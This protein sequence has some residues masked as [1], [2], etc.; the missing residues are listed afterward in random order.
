MRQS[1]MVFANAAARSSAITAPT[2]GMLTYLSDSGGLFIYNGSA[3][4]GAVNASSL[5]GQYAL[6][7]ADVG[8]NTGTAGAWRMFTLP[9]GKM[10]LDV[11]SIVPYGGVNDI[12]YL[13]G[14]CLG[15]WSGVQ[16]PY[17]AQVYCYLGNAVA[18][19][20]STIRIYYR[21]PQ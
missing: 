4:V 5:N 17:Q 21:N 15:N 20:F 2:Q 18:S 14:V 9:A 12:V 16:N 19:S 1:V 6:T 10:F 11:A 8:I 7:Y 13:L 3:W